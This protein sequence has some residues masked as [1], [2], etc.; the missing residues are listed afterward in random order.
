MKVAHALALITLSLIAL[1]C[2][3]APSVVLFGD[4]LSDNGNGYAGNAKY[5]LRT[6]QASHHRPIW[7]AVKPPLLACVGP[8]Y[9]SCYDFPIC[10]SYVPVTD[11]P[12]RTLLQWALVKWAHLD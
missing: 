3:S 4:S 10:N 8:A 12:S 5:V 9:T 6:N 11:V 1:R 2:S 7:K